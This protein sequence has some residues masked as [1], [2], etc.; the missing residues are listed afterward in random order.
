MND[1]MVFGS[2]F[3]PGD[4]SR[5]EKVKRTRWCRPVFFSE[6]GKKTMSKTIHHISIWKNEWFADRMYDG[7]CEETHR[8][9]FF[10]PKHVFF[11]KNPMCLQ[12]RISHCHLSIIDF[13][14][15]GW[16][17]QLYL[18]AKV[19]M[20]V[21]VLICEV[22][23]GGSRYHDVGREH[24]LWEM[25]QYILRDWRYLFCVWRTMGESLL[26]NYFKFFFNHRWSGVVARSSLF[27]ICC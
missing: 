21:W 19:F 3:C 22:L 24:I 25:I 6:W 18:P 27:V 2:F 5:W 14:G 23:G 9:F 26:F 11:Q 7:D 16:N 13:W 15:G 17:N 4:N 10:R 8:S 1:I 12:R 20:C